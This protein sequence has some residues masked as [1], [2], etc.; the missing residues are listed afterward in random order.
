MDENA[1]AIIYFICW[2]LSTLN[3]KQFLRSGAVEA[4][5]QAIKNGTPEIAIEIAKVNTNILWNCTDPED[6]RNMFACAVAH[7]QEEVAQFLYGF[8]ARIGTNMVFTT[9]KDG[10]NLLHLAAKLAPRSYLDCIPG[11]ALQLQSELRW[12]KWKALFHSST[13]MI[14]IMVVKLLPKCLLR[15]TSSC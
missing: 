9:D 8:N 10:N 5:F 2:R 15:N 6:S 7:R 13:T 11:A 14:K 4:T 12:F 1:R 3:E